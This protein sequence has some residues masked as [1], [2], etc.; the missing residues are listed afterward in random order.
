M[1]E[2]LPP[3]V[4]CSMTFKRFLVA[5]L[6]LFVLW[7]GPPAISR[8]SSPHATTI[9][10]IG[11]GP[12]TAIDLPNPFKATLTG[13]FPY[14]YPYLVQLSPTARFQPNFATKWSFS[15]NHRV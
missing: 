15:R 7:S 12:F 11:Q 2:D 5:L 13:E 10:K 6:T 4:R 1:S 14:V 3:L 9:F 8:A